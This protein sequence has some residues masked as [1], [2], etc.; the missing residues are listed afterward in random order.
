[1][2]GFWWPQWVYETSPLVKSGVW[3]F[4]L[5]K[6]VLGGSCTSAQLAAPEATLALLLFVACCVLA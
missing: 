1:M 4:Q 2:L 6:L 3:Y 5:N